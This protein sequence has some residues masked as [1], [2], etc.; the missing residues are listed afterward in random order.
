[1]VNAFTKF[2][3]FT[4]GLL[5]GEHH[6]A[7]GGDVVKVYLTNNAPDTEADTIKTDLAGITEEN[8]YVATDIQNDVSEALGVASMTG[9][10]VEWTVDA[11]EDATGLGPFQYAVLYNDT[12][13][14]D[15][16]IGWFDYGAPVTLPNVGEKFKVDF[17]ATVITLT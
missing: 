11:D 8:G 15:A 16:L 13:A 9:V 6:L 10:D 7:A 17:A 2:R 3:H 4:L 5:N 1:M 12:H 14:S